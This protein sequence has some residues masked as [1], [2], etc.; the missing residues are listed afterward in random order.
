M[1]L[2]F[3]VLSCKAHE[4]FM[5][6]PASHVQAT[7]PHQSHVCVTLLLQPVTANLRLRGG[8]GENP[9][10]LKICYGR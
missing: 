9:T 3:L 1:L 5:H 2:C 10:D 8:Q 4:C 6:S 7:F